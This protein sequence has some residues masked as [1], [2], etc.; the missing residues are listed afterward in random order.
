MYWPNL[1]SD[2]IWKVKVKVK[3]KVKMRVKVKVKVKVKILGKKFFFTKNSPNSLKIILEQKK[4][5]HTRPPPWSWPWPPPWGRP[6]CCPW[7]RPSQF[8]SSPNI[9]LYHYKYFWSKKFFWSARH[10]QYVLYC[11]VLYSTVLYCTPVQYTKI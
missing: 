5:F 3:V 6:P 10:V 8:F 2:K 4:N 11:T 9:I 7:G 1:D